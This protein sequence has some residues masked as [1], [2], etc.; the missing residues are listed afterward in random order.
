MR[1]LHFYLFG[2]ATWFLSFGVQGVMFAWLVTM[3]LHESPEMVG[4]AQMALLLPGTL[5]ILIGGSYADRL[6]GLRVAVVAQFAAAIGPLVL[7]AFISRDALSF[8][9]MIGYAIFM[10]CAQA[11][12]TPARDGLLNQVAEGRVQ[13]TVMLASVMQFG[14]QVA[15][16]A[17]ASQADRIGAVPILAIQAVVLCLGVFSFTRMR[18]GSPPPA[19][20]APAVAHPP[21]LSSLVEGART[22]FSIPAIRMVMLQNAAMGLFFMGSFIV[23]VPLAVRELFDGSSQDLGLVSGANS[24]GLMLTIL[25]LL[26][27]GDI[28]RQGR[29]LLLAQAAGCLVL[30]FSSLAPDMLRF[31]LAIFAWGI[32]GGLGLTMS[33]T[34]MQEQ[35]PAA[36]RSRVMSF[37]S[38]TFL[39][40]GP[41]G[42]LLCGFMV[43]RIG[44][45]A[46]LQ[47]AG[48]AM[49][50]VVLIVATRSGLWH[51]DSR[52]L[53]VA[54]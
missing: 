38:F 52:R 36:Q 44:V 27:L 32:C 23:T 26:R 12:V 17:L 28:H 48:V 19:P 30:V 40:A 18:L 2:T 50:L 31:V 4:V 15:G 46:A 10:G 29:A 6:G 39:G 8:A 37:Y 21:L 53:A 34:I 7:L 54:A 45:T 20:A 35:A 1:P 14:L 47:T 43:E 25:L 42:A 22:C 13:R 33:R 3:V 41:V 5:L 51:L 49:L 16:Y 9:V 24:L 11:F